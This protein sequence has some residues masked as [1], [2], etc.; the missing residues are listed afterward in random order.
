M[1]SEFLVREFKNMEENCCAVLRICKLWEQYIIRVHI[2][3][4]YTGVYKVKLNM[5]DKFFT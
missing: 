5:V 2:K 1:G 4:V 3:T